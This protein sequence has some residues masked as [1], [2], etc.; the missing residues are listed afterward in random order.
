MVVTAAFC[1]VWL[2]PWAAGKEQLIVEVPESVHAILRFEETGSKLWL[3][4]EKNLWLY[5][6][7]D[8][9]KSVAK[10]DRGFEGSALDENNQN[11]FY[12][13]GSDLFF[14]PLSAKDPKPTQFSRNPKRDVDPVPLLG[15]KWVLFASDRDGDFDL[16]VVQR[17]GNKLHRFLKREG[18][19]RN[20]DLSPDGRRV[21]WISIP[22]KRQ[23]TSQIF[24]ADIETVKSGDYPVAKNVRGVT[25]GVPG[26]FLQPH[27]AGNDRYLFTA[28]FRKPLELEGFAAELADSKLARVKSLGAPRHYPK[29]SIESGSHAWIENGQNSSKLLSEKME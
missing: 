26:L 16:Y 12:S 28:N 6:A 3:E 9:L 5:T 20:P 23:D 7:A 24:V 8:G 15:G 25:E 22:P 18:D 17:D 21:M 4:G 19:D 14:Q 27:W 11:I 2:S 10:R 29:Q 13:T 1:A